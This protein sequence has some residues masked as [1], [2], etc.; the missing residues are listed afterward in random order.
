MIPEARD[1]LPL[2]SSVDE[3]G[4]EWSGY[5]PNVVIGMPATAVGGSTAALFNAWTDA[6]AGAMVAC[7]QGVDGGIS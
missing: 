4:Q 6:A 3:R 1:A 5:V 2:R 7:A